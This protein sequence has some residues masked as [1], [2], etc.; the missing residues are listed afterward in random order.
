MDVRRL[1]LAAGCT[2]LDR[3]GLGRLLARVTGG[4]GLI[5]TLHSVVPCAGGRDGSPNA[6]LR[7]TPEFLERTILQIRASGIEIVPLAEAVERGLSDRAPGGPR[8]AALTFDDGYRDNLVHALPVLERHAVPF[9]IFVTTGFV[10]RTAEIWWEALARIVS[11]AAEIEVPVGAGMRRFPTATQADRRRVFC[12][13]LYWF[14]RAL[15]E[16]S[17]R[18]ELRRLAARHG[19]D[20]AALADELILSWDELRGLCAH[21]LFTLG[22]HT[23]DHFALAR[24]PRERMEADIARGMERLWQELGIRP[25]H[26]AYPY[27]YE[28][29]VNVTARDVVRDAGFDAAVTT[30]LGVFS[31]REDR[32]A[33]PRVSLN[34]YFQDAA[35][36]SQYLTG[37]PFP[38]YNLARRLR[39]RIN[40]HPACG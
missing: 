33:L 11:R 15:G 9:T 17:Q 28:A 32:F 10:D 24:L 36:V 35:V 34:G 23:H 40:P 7:V 16:E 37:A 13:L 8:F 29:A 19:V 39:D 20:L 31:G 26:F 1:V 2:V 21:P 22:A 3:S 38:V 30:R 6:H 4:R 14:T 18:L 12:H 25:R 5:F 27:G